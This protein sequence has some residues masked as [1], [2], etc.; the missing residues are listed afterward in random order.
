MSTMHMPVPSSSYLS[1]HLQMASISPRDRFISR[2]LADREAVNRHRRHLRLLEQ[3]SG[4][5]R[6]DWVTRRIVEISEL[7]Y[8][9]ATVSQLDEETLFVRMSFAGGI[10][11]D[12][13]WHSA[14]D[15]FIAVYREDQSVFAGSGTVSAALSDLRSFL[16][17]A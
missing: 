16:Q 5:A 1:G 12:L 17:P 3:L 6:R 8:R 4:N 7:S 9:T 14:G 11:A 15:A 10:D 13:Q 2:V